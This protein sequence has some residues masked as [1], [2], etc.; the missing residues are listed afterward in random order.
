MGN[1]M[2]F[3]GGSTTVVVP[4][5]FVATN[6]PDANTTAKT[7]EPSSDDYVAPWAGSIVAISARHNADLSGGVITWTPTIAGTAKTALSIITD[8][9]NQQAY[10]RIPA[11]VIPFAAGDRLGAAMTKTGTVAP[12]TT[13]VALTLYV[14]YDGVDL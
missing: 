3:L 1:R 4:L 14:A 11:G 12:T 7:V 6:V 13:D 8:D 5:P 10:A 2:Q 9:T